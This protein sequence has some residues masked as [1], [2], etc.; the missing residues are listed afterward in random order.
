MSDR[1]LR[2]ILVDQAEGSADPLAAE[3]ARTG[4]EVVLNRVDTEDALASLLRTTAPDVVFTTPAVTQC[5][6]GTVLR[7][8]QSVRPT[9]PVILLSDVSDQQV[10]V[11][12]VRAGIENVVWKDRMERVAE[13][14]QNALEVRRPLSKLSPRQI[15][16]LRLIAQGFTTKQIAQQLVLSE[17]T[18]ETHRSAVAQRLG[19]RDVAGLVRYAVRVG[20]A[21]QAPPFDARRREA[22]GGLAAGVPHLD[23]SAVA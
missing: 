10:T 16:V 20:L 21:S 12:C 17:K 13:V 11:A 14:F 1:P 19:I 23:R 3:L 15:E 8:V 18:I 6:T 4:R 9:V 5:A 2:A 7:T 22:G